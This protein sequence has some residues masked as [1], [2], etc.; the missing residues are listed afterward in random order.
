[1]LVSK[2]RPYKRIGFIRVTDRNI[3]TKQTAQQV[4]EGSES[5][6]VSQFAGCALQTELF[7][8][9][10]SDLLPF[11]FLLLLHPLGFEDLFDA[12]L[13]QRQSFFLV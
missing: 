1:M 10:L 8:P 6:L 11:V 2:S 4:G 9:L 3:H 7:E 5:V 12:H 13:F